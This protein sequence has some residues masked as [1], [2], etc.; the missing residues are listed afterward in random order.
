M[1]IGCRNFV[2]YFGLSICYV[3]LYLEFGKFLVICDME[4]IKK[5][6]W[7]V[8]NDFYI[9]WIIVVWKVLMFLFVSLLSFEVW[10]DW[11]CLEL[12]LYDYIKWVY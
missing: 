7:K 9:F 1:L 5:F 10:K 6:I 11:M 4:K 8:I 3:N 12:K 2:Y